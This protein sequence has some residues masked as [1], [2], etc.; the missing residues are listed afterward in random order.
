MKIVLA[1]L[2]SECFD[3]S[4]EFGEYNEMMAKIQQRVLAQIKDDQRRKHFAMRQALSIA[5]IAAVLVS[6][7]TVTAYALGLFK[8][9]K[10]L[11]TDD[12]IPR[13]RWIERDSAGQIINIQDMDYPDANLFFTF[14]VMSSPTTLS[15]SL[16]G[17]QWKASVG[18][19][20]VGTPITVTRAIL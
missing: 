15:S 16:D 8:L 11:I 19:K 13:G 1:D 20:T 4:I 17:C 2:A 5:I 10:N 9:N 3:E 7:L 12:Y 6:L 14:D 18:E